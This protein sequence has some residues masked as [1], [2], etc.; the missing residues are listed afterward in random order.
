MNPR[1][2]IVVLFLVIAVRVIFAS[3]TDEKTGSTKQLLSIAAQLS[4]IAQK[5]TTNYPT[6]TVRQQ[7]DALIEPVTESEDLVRLALLCH[8]VLG[9]GAAE[10]ASYDGVFDYAMWHC[11][12]LLSQRPGRDGEEALVQLQPYIGRDGGGALTMRELIAAQK[13]PP[14]SKK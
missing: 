3:S 4:E 2:S 8:A 1:F 12:R 5:Q 11:A 13:K 7:I 14:A 9:S 10:H 6:D